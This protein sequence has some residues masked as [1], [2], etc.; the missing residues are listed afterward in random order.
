MPPRAFELVG[1]IDPSGA[2][3]SHIPGEKKG[4]LYCRLIAW[5]RP[6][7]PIERGDFMI[8]M[9]VG[10]RQLKRLA[11]EF[12]A[13][14]VIKVRVRYTHEDVDDAIHRGHITKLL[15]DGDDAELL[16]LAASLQQPLVHEDPD[17]GP[18]TY[19]REYGCWEG[20]LDWP[21]QSRRVELVLETP[22]ESLAGAPE[23]AH[24]R[25][26]VTAAEEWT[27]KARRFAAEQLLELKNDS[28][29]DGEDEL[30]TDQFE[31]A[32]GPVAHLGVSADRVDLML[33]DGDLFFGHGIRV[34]GRP[35]GELTRA[36]MV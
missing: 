2:G 4:R 27:R 19:K 3:S 36:K 29:L 8:G 33:R 30:T 9:P 7:E 12:A 34:A 6:G 17:L 1:L 31:A 22:T 26:V 15:G 13:Y 16:A 20:A 35:S 18:L 25:A 11:P 21:G 23:L 5:R 24:A 28:W 10:P 14:R 32:I